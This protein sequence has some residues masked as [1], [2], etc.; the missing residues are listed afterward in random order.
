MHAQLCLNFC[1]SMD[2]SPP[3]SSVHGIFQARILEWVAI[4]YS[5]G[6]SQPRAQS[7][8]SYFSCSGR[9]IPFHWANWGARKDLL[10]SVFF[11]FFFNQCI[12]LNLQWKITRHNERQKHNL[13]KQDTALNIYILKQRFWNYHKRI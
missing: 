11:F 8:I 5:K 1:D 2:C 6:S 7:S 3:V 9:Q 10:A 13:K 12:M 4:S